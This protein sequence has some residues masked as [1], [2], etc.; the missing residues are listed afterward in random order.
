MPAPGAQYPV[1]YVAGTGTGTYG[2]VR[3]DD[4]GITW[5]R[6]NDDAHQFGSLDVIAGDPRIYGRVYLGTS[7]RGVVYGDIA[8]LRIPAH[9]PRA[10]PRAAHPP[11]HD[12][13][14]LGESPTY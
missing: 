4:A 14:V 7:G 9:E 12:N 11:V 2:I 10:H 5:T 3:S 13:A 1:L 8:P 6:V